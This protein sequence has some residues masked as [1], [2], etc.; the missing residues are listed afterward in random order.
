MER[1]YLS[2]PAIF[3]E[4]GSVAASEVTSST[5]RKSLKN[6]VVHAVAIAVRVERDF[7]ASRPRSLTCFDDVVIVQ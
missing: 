3:P 7:P 5:R 4:F 1:L 6:V 2:E